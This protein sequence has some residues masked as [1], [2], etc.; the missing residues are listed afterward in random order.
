[1][2]AWLQ[3]IWSDEAAFKAAMRVLFKWLGGVAGAAISADIVPT[4][5]DGGWKL[6]LMLMVIALGAPTQPIAPPKT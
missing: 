1:M 4:G 2:V 6:G 5:I 3:R